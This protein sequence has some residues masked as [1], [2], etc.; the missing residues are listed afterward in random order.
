MLLN[1]ELARLFAE[2]IRA[3]LPRGAQDVRVMIP[4]IALFVRTMDTDIGHEPVALH[5][6]TAELQRQRLTLLVVQLR[7]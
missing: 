2:S 5:Q 6:L 7:R 1:V 4:L 3:D